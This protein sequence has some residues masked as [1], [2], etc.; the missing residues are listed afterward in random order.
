[1]SVFL[2]GAYVL[3]LWLWAVWRIL[4]RRRVLDGRSADRYRPH[5][6]PGRQGGPGKGQA[7]EDP[8]RLR[9]RLRQPSTTARIPFGTGIMV[10][11]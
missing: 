10:V 6:H 11:S 4:I 3:R 2:T 8:G 5:V 7:H 1:M 9:Q